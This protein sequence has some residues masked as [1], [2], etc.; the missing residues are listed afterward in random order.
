[1]GSIHLS[2]GYVRLFPPS[3][4]LTVAG[5]E[6]VYTRLLWL[7]PVEAR[8]HCLL[9]PVSCTQLRPT[10]WVCPRVRSDS[11]QPMPAP[12]CSK[13]P[14]RLSGRLV[15]CEQR[16]QGGTRALPPPAGL[17]LCSAP[18]CFLAPCAYCDLLTPKPILSIKD[19]APTVSSSLFCLSTFSSGH[20]PLGLSCLR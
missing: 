1:M 19:V 18:T 17:H 8:G 3:L 11:S 7:C 16:L 13:P 5:E 15:S 4:S 12:G 20:C 10:S 14:L 6:L 9:I 2:S